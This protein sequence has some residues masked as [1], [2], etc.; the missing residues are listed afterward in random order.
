VA[1]DASGFEVAAAA[2][3]GAHVPARGFSAVAS[4]S[5]ERLGTAARYRRSASTALETGSS[6][7]AWGLAGLLC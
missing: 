6:A 4:L 1:G 3:A 2:L 7:V 5:G